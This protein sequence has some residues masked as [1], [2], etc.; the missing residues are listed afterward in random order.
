MRIGRDCRQTLDYRRIVRP[1]RTDRTRSYRARRSCCCNKP[2]GVLCQFTR[3]RRAAARSP[4]SCRCRDVYPAGRLDA[5]SEGLVVL[6]ADGALQ[7]RIA[8]PRHKLAKTYWVQVEGTP[9][10]AQLAA[11]APRR[12]RCAT[13]TTAPARAR[14]D[15]RAAATVAARPADP[16]AQGDSHRVARADARRRPQSPG[17]ADDRGGRA[18]DAAPHPLSRRPVD[19][20]RPRARA[21]RGR[22]HDAP[23]DNIRAR[24]R[25]RVASAVSAIAAF[26]T[27]P[28]DPPPARP[29][30]ARPA[31]TQAAHLRP[32]PASGPPRP[33]VRAARATSRASCR[34]PDSR[35]S[36]SAARCATCC[37]ASTPKDFDIATDATPEQVKPLFRRAFIIGR[38]FRLVHVHAGHEVIEVSTFRAAQTGDDATDEHG[39]LLSDNVY[40]TQ[41]EDAAR[42]DFTINALYFDPDDR[43][44][45]GLR[46]RRRRHPRAAAEADRP[47]GHALP[48]RP[49]AHAARGAARREARHRD[50][51]EDRGAD[52]EARAADRRTCRRRA[53]ST[54]CRSCC[55]PGHAARDAARACAR[56]ACSTAC[57]RCSTSSSSSRSASA[58]S[59]LALANTDERVREDK[60]RLAGVPVRH[61]AV[62]RGAGARG[63]RR[64]A[65]GEK[66]LPGAVRCDGPGARA[67][68][69]SASR[70]RAASRR[71]SRRSGRCSR[72][73]SSARASVRSRCSSIRAF[74]PRYDF[75]ALR[76]ESGE[77][78][79]SARSTGGRAS[80]TRATPS[81]QAMLKPDEAPK[82]RRRSRGRG[83]KKQR[84]VRRGRR[85]AA[86]A[87]DATPDA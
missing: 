7:A 6:T 67:R 11:L 84:G 76:G 71:R 41:A 32:R 2:Y 59:M 66:P 87:D 14:V 51:A 68:R 31:G 33:A 73:S 80:R 46:R 78:P 86:A 74:A 28:D 48:R 79:A 23:R 65:R 5:D 85:A 36:S 38:R 4:I 19:A 83:R 10:A 17:A 53:C 57:C 20:R 26:A 64:K 29:P 47:A 16:R 49:G 62:A 69:R 24:S 82:K 27:P 18:A 21:S 55:C 52:P 3:R 1:P 39:R 58:S 61:A 75:L 25:P 72:A 13:F 63:T 34:K 42:R 35:P 60:R 15:R 44:G 8:D 54:R 40:G 30:H 22:V 43:G 45:L 56:T 9:A 77:V 37:S 81:A 12:R 70:S 50:R